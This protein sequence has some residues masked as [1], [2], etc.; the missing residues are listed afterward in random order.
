MFT[1]ITKHTQ[2]LSKT[3]LLSKRYEFDDHHVTPVP[4][5]TVQNCQAYVLFYRKCNRSIM[6][7]QSEAQD[8]LDDLPVDER[9]VSVERQCNIS[10]QWWH[11]FQTFA[12]PGPIDNWS[13]LCPHGEIHPNDMD[14]VDQMAVALPGQVWDYLYKRFGGGPVLSSLK[15]CEVC[16]KELVRRERRREYEF[17]TFKLLNKKFNNEVCEDSL[18]AISMEWYRTWEAFV[19]RTTDQEPGPIDNKPIAVSSEQG[20]PKRLVRNGADYA[21]INTALWDFFHNIY[22]GGPKI[23]IREAPLVAVNDMEGEEDDAIVS[24]F[25]RLS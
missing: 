7:A 17:N 18:Y 5:E 3:H 23:L 8:I 13:F 20:Y 1:P 4:E 14:R 10:R 22:G 9:S 25:S 2:V 15:E 6:K 21:Q 11:R 12:D 16:K 19:D 24:F